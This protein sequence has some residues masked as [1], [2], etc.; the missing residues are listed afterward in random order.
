MQRKSTGLLPRLVFLAVM[1]VAVWPAVAAAQWVPKAGDGSISI[2]YQYTRVESHLFSV[3]LTGYVDPASGY[4]GGPGKR[5]YLGDVF[6]QTVNVS[7]DYG[8][9][10]GLALSVGAAYEGAKYTGRSPESTEDDGQFHGSLQDGTVG[11]QYMATWQGIVVTPSIGMRFPLAN[12]ETLGHVAVGSHLREYP[13][14]IAVGRALDPILPRAYIG[15]SFTYA[16]VQNLHDFSLDQHRYELDAGYILNDKVSFGG[17]LSYAS[18]V[19]GLDWA[20][21]DL[22]VAEMFSEHD[23][24][25]KAKYLRAGAHITY[26]MAGAFSLSA[27]Y[28]GTL[29]GQNTHDAQSITFSPSWSFHAPIIH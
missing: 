1:C 13:I 21:D 14:G 24:A 27:L 7:T 3:D 22:S 17:S 5:A 18:T 26:S 11:L 23:A 20:K 10:R 28:V 12:Y 6:G 8:I 29:S 4:I 9:W 15:G 25:A 2:G 19:D 16:F